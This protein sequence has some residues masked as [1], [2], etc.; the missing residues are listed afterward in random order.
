MHLKNLVIVATLLFAA[1]PVGA[2][3]IIHLTHPFH[4][5]PPPGDYLAR[6]ETS[7]FT[8]VEKMALLK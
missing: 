2:D 5:G 6:L 8:T 4:D 3:T 1:V 7:S